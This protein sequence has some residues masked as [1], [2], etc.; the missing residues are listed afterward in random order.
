MTLSHHP[1]DDVLIRYAAATLSEGPSIVI[2]V[3]LAVC[4]NCRAR[5]DAFETLGGAVLQTLEPIQM[6]SE[7]LAGVLQRIDAE[8]AP[9]QPQYAP[10]IP[11][12]EIVPGVAVPEAMRSLTIGRWRLLAPGLQ[13]SRLGA[14]GR[15][16][17]L[18]MLRA[19]PGSSLM[20]HSHTGDEYIC[21]LKGSFSDQDGRYQPGDMAIADVEIEHKPGV[22]SDGECICVVALEGKLRLKSLVGRI[23]QP[24][25]GL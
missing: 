18:F 12:A 21:V 15:D 11:S 20:E 1:D 19:A 13:I 25:Y 17:N 14:K 23:L 2:G 8:T 16:M 22:E 4:T 7:A 3:H 6:A 5:V 9:S 24:I 10:S